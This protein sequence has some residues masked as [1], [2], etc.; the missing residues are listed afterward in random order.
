MNPTKWKSVVIPIGGYKV[1]RKMATDEHGEGPFSRKTLW[2]PE[3][4]RYQGASCRGPR[5]PGLRSLPM[6]HR[7]NATGG[8]Q[9]S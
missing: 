4:S 1:L 3:P 6:G 9:S 7:S 8:I 5:G 2:L